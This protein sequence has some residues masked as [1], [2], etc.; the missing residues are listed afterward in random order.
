MDVYLSIYLIRKCNAPAMWKINLE[1]FEVST[2]EIGHKRALFPTS[3]IWAL[4]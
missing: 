3:I 1:N 4:K 2:A